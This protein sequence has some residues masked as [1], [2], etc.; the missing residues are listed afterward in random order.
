MIHKI[1]RASA[2]TGK[3]ERLAGRLVELV[4]D[5][6]AAVKMQEIVALTFS[7]AAA[8]EIFERFLRLLA[9]KAKENPSSGAADAIRAVV[10]SQHLSQMGTLDSFL[11]RMVR[12]FPLELGLRGDLEIM[13]DFESEIARAAVSFEIL[14]R[15]DAASKRAFVEAFSLVMNRERVRKFIETYRQFIS[16]WHENFLSNKEES[17]WGD[18]T[19]I[20]SPE[21][22]IALAGRE[23]LIRAAEELDKLDTSK[24]WQNF[25]DWVRSFKGSFSDIKGYAA[26][27][28]EN[29]ELFDHST[30]E[31]SFNRK[32]IVF[33][34]EKARAVRAAVASVLGYV[35]RMKLESARGIYSLVAAF[36]SLYAA[37]V[38]SAGKLVFAD[39]PRL[40]E[41]LDFSNRAALEYR[42]DSCIKAWALDEFQ[43]TSRE[44]WNALGPLIEEARSSD[45][46]PVLIVGDIKQAIYGWRNGDVGI[47]KKE[48]SS[49]CYEEEILDKSWRSAPPIIEAVNAVFAKGMI[50]EFFPQ[51]EMVEHYSAREELEGFVQTVEA[52][53]SKKEDFALPIA[54][55]LK[56]VNP[57]AKGISAAVLVRNNTLG[58]ELA[59]AL[60]RYDVEGVV[61]E[62][63]S[64]ILDTP[65]LSPF[66][67]VVALADHPGDMRAYRH[68]IRSPL[69]ASLY[70][71]EVPPAGE[72]SAFYARAFAERGM[73][74]VL[75]ELR[76]ALPSESAAAWSEFTE[77][78]FTGLLRAAAEFELTRRADTRLAD[79]SSFLA[80]R[81]KRN[82]AEPGKI[83]I[84]S[85]HRSKGLAFDYVILPLYESRALDSRPGGP[86]KGDGWILPDPG[87]YVERFARNI[88]ASFAKAFEDARERSALEELCIY[89]VAMTRA[90]RAM[91]IITSPPRKK[92]SS[93]YFSDIVRSAIRNPIG[94]KEWHLSLGG[95]SEGDKSADTKIEKKLPRAKR[96]NIRRRL[97]SLPFVSGQSAGDLFLAG[98]SRRKALQRGVDVHAEFERVEWIDAASA[99][100]DFDRALVRP[101]GAVCLWREKAFEIFQ[102]D[103]WTS[104]RVDRVVFTEKDGERYARIQDFKTDRIRRNES[105]EAFR[106]RMRLDYA[107]QM[108]AYRRAVSSLTGIS[109]ENVSAELLVVSTRAVIA[110]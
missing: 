25:A 23:D 6:S 31:F 65:A 106:E 103:S 67:D 12:A 64:D 81:T 46:K 14:R 84:L 8:G 2:G 56:A 58:V 24:E 79:F 50:G 61:W 82:V 13:S 99:A 26:K 83:K 20:I 48:L 1:I 10:A 76:S 47:M 33:S 73:V 7:R 109:E 17:A 36:E 52:S 75:R 78:R 43:D 77:S 51:W 5:P 62:G 55:A 88:S 19:K 97:P 85:I 53:S 89:Y 30:I 4:S 96:V 40:V 32:A 69:A 72:L 63:E 27:I 3:T 92:S 42:I 41:A 60:R 37:K 100:D 94:N 93:L 104:G 101:E 59:E 105:E 86:V 38:R 70:K 35:L 80:S 102:S 11:M 15:T 18:A 44:Q 95:K 90:R 54:N 107:P 108:A 110:V 39:V 91:T 34:G 22:P 45:E 49:Q 57:I 66:L 71:G 16:S 98:V 9:K 87:E 28:L 68:F 74:R 21:S 29:D